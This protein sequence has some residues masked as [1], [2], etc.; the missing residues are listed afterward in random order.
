[1]VLP[2]T[3]LILYQDLP[4]TARPEHVARHAPP[5]TVETTDTFVPAAMIVRARAL[6]DGVDRRLTRQS[7]DVVLAPR[8]WP[9]NET[10]ATPNTRIADRSEM[11]RSD[12]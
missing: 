12:E 11:A 2:A 4:D 1:M 8:T 5:V 3:A 7:A 9:G 6:V 10:A